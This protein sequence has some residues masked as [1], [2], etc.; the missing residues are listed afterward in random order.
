MGNLSMPCGAGK[1]GDKE[2]ERE[3]PLGRHGGRGCS[4]APQ[5]EGGP[6]EGLS[7]EVAPAG[8]ALGRTWKRGSSGIREGRCTLAVKPRAVC[9][10]RL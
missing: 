10:R 7:W 3:G 8:E 4:P 6:C 9:H 1:E 2:G 5:A